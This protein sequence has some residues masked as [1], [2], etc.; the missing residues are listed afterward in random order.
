MSKKVKDTIWWYLLLK[1]FYENIRTT[2]YG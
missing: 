1:C 2:R